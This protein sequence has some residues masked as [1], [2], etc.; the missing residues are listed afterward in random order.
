MN[1]NNPVYK[2]NFVATVLA[3]DVNYKISA[4][5][6]AHPEEKGWEVGKIQK[7]DLGN[8]Y[9][10]LTIPLAKYDLEQKQSNSIHM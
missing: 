9:V 1:N 7:E 3:A 10:R 4:V 8:G 6:E 2:E 5:I